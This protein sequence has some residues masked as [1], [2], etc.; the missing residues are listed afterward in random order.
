MKKE[1]SGVAARVYPAVAP[2]VEEQGCFV[3][4]IEFVR[5]GA[6]QILRITIDTDADAGISIDECE[7]VHRAVDPVLD[8]LDPIE[9]AYYLQVSSPGVERSLT[10]PWHVAAC[11]GEKV[12]A[13]LFAP[14]GGKK[15]LTG[16]LLGFADP[17]AEEGIMIDLGTETVTL[18]LE[19]VSKLTTVFDFDA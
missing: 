10:R 11:A 19:T 15:K 7:R 6:D 12:E 14:V 4:D 17:D 1:M 13:R 9:S 8:E 18:P 3:W 16:T 5:E 2:V